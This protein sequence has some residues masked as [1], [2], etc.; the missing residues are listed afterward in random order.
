[1]GKPSGLPARQS[2]V[3]VFAAT[4]SG[5]TSGPVKHL[6]YGYLAAGPERVHG[7]REGR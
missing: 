2:G 5:Q 4:G 7:L 1:M 6:A 3:C